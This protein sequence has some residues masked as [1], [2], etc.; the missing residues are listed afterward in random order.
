MYEAQLYST[1]Y[2]SDMI[3]FMR[4]AQHRHST[5]SCYFPM[6]FTDLREAGHIRHRRLRQRRATTGRKVVE[7][8]RYTAYG[9]LLSIREGRD[10]RGTAR[11][12]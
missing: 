5:V 7:Y 12:G 9:L 4:I 8:S 2:L 6:C 3:S 1:L 11:N 10:G